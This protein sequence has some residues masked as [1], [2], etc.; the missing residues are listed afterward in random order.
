MGA[1]GNKSPVSINSTGGEELKLRRQTRKHV[2]NSIL[3]TFPVNISVESRN[4]SAQQEAA[5]DKH[6][7]HFAPI[8]AGITSK[9]HRRSYK[10]DAAYV[11]RVSCA[12]YPSTH[13]RTRTRTG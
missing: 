4:S 1:S 9:M 3:R 8:C 11:T 2:I 10:E 6:H 12:I 5:A 13:T 7:R